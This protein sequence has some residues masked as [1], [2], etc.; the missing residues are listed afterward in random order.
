MKLFFFST[1][2]SRVRILHKGKHVFFLPR[3]SLC[4]RCTRFES[5]DSVEFIFSFNSDKEKPKTKNNPS[6]YCLSRLHPSPQPGCATH[7]SSS[8][9]AVCCHH[10]PC[11]WVLLG[12]V[13][14]LFCGFFFLP[15]SSLI[16]SASSIKSSL[17]VLQSGWSC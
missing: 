16:A 17:F 12:M 6:L 5:L 13:S 9:L 1:T 11:F 2:M 4:F 3:L 10:H 7:S 8:P 14:I 15:F